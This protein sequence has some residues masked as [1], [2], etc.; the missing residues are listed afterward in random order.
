MNTSP[1]HINSYTGGLDKDTS[2]NKYDNTHYYHAENFRILT[3]K[4]LTSGMLRSVEGAS[5]LFNFPANYSYHGHTFIRDYV[6]LFMLHTGTEDRI[7]YFP[8]N[9]PTITGGFLDSS[10]L[11]YEGDLNWH[12]DY[13]VQAEGRYES[14]NIQKV[15]FVDGYNNIRF[16]NLVEPGISSKEANYLSILPE[17]YQDVLTIT[18]ISNDGSLVGGIIEY[19]AIFYTP[20]GLESV[21]SQPSDRVQ[22]TDGNLTGSYNSI[23]GVETG[24]NT[25]KS[26]SILITNPDTSLFNQVRL[27]SIHYQEYGANPILTIIGDYELNVSLVVRDSGTSAIG[28]YS[29]EEYNRLKNIFKAKTLATKNNYLFAGNI[30]EIYTDIDYDSRAYRFQQDPSSHLASATLNGGTGSQTVDAIEIANDPVNW[31]IPLTHDAVNP[32]LDLSPDAAA[33]TIT[34]SVYDFRQTYSDLISTWTNGPTLYDTFTITQ[35]PGPENYSVAA[36]SSA[37]A[38]GY[39]NTISLEQ[40]DV[41][42]FQAS[43]HQV[44]GQACVLK[45]YLGATFKTSHNLIEG[46]N[47][48]S[49]LIDTD[50]DYLFYITN[51]AASSFTLTKYQGKFITVLGGTGPNVSYKFKVD[52]FV[53]DEAVSAND[54]EYNVWPFTQG[55]KGSIISPDTD[56]HGTYDNFVSP[57][58]TIKSLSF[59]RDE[60]YRIGLEWYDTYGRPLFVDWVGDIR[61]PSN[62]DSNYNYSFVSVSGSQ[63]LM[64]PLTLKLSVKITSELKDNNIAGFKI[65]RCIRT[66]ENKTVL[67][68]GLIGSL[69]EHPTAGSSYIF[70][71]TVNNGSLGQAFTSSGY[72]DSLDGISVAEGTFTNDYKEY[73]SAEVDFNKENTFIGNSYLKAE[74]DLDAYLTTM[75]FGVN[76]DKLKT[77]GKKYHILTQNAS[78]TASRY[79]ELDTILFSD[80]SYDASITTTAYFKNINNSTIYNCSL[81]A[82]VR[83]SNDEAIGTCLVIYGT[84]VNDAFDYTKNYHA[85]YATR[86]RNISPYGGTSYYTRINSE[87]ITCSPYYDISSI[88]AGSY[89]SAEA[90]GDTYLFMH[91]HLRTQTSQ[92]S[93]NTNGSGSEVILYPTESSF[94]GAIRIGTTLSKSASGLGEFSVDVHETLGIY[95]NNDNVTPF[96]QTFNYYNYNKVYNTED[97]SKIFI[98]EPLNY[99]LTSIIL[100]DTQIA[101]SEKK[102]NN[103]LID[104]WALFY[105]SNE[106]E[107]DG[108]YGAITKLIN[109]NNTLFAIQERGIAAIAVEEKEAVQTGTISALAIGYSGVLSRYDYLSIETGTSMIDSIVKT[110][111]QLFWYDDTNNGIYGFKNLTE[112]SITKT[113]GMNSWFNERT[114]TKVKSGYDRDFNEVL[115][116]LKDSNDNVNTLVFNELTGSFISFYTIPELQ[117]FIYSDPILLG[118]TYEATNKVYQHNNSTTR[119]F[120]T[121]L[122]ESKLTLVVKPQYPL[123]C[124]FDSMEWE[125]SVINT[126]TTTNTYNDY[127]LP[128]IDE[129]ALMYS[130]LKTA[131]LG[132][133]TNNRYWSS[134]EY[135]TGYA[136]YISF[137]DGTSYFDSKSNEY[138]VRAMR[139]YKTSTVY[140]LTGIGQSGGRVFNIITNTDG[141]YTYFEA[142]VSDIVSIV[143]W[144]N[145]SILLGTTGSLIFSGLDNTYKIIGQVGHTTSAAKSCY[146]LTDTEVV[147]TLELPIQS[148]T[149]D[150][151]R[152]YNTYQDSGLLTITSAQNRFRTWRFNTYRDYV[153]GSRAKL[154]DTFMKVDLEWTPESNKYLV[155]NDVRTHYLPNRA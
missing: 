122:P 153:N 136:R 60:I 134:T 117:N 3:D 102:I 98:P 54:T 103:E 84:P 31:G 44:S 29:L 110:A 76:V 68:S 39:S 74:Y 139:S 91:E 140:T 7:Y 46:T 109:F 105:F 131:G 101:A 146:D 72:L 123:A 100:S 85:I 58:R 20:T 99:F 28:E 48:V 82:R 38:Q 5:L 128:S 83:N 87:Y 142:A 61:F 67:D 119:T 95:T 145:L 59:R 151:M 130:V 24:A 56:L 14:T 70:P 141:T 11:K 120:Y 25:F 90:T 63:I 21:F 22:L 81:G 92:K 10:Y 42:T 129:L 78:I 37:A 26:V 62:T 66:D 111:N 65:V 115:F 19:I 80:T 69:E 8:I 79:S 9:N 133:F 43:Y 32:Y 15:Y 45:L 30:E 124:R 149:I 18:D 40:G 6:V 27:V 52:S 51:T 121:A 135:S 53:E 86:K 132:G 41:I 33:T 152:F 36:A 137:T 147:S 125:S 35:T 155:L 16:L 64:H 93:G 1:I 73:C 17:L 89:V 77:T 50:G 23:M 96:M 104:S 143:V 57:Y 106:I 75:L 108:K 114:F 113:L 154:R 49:F 71:F 97:T 55:Y 112:P 47:I 138:K 148:E 144:S 126:G 34:D 2:V 127:Y 88:S 4:G 12:V 150:K 116:Q 118:V 107:V 94:N 13:P